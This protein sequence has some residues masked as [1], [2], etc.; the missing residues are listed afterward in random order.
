MR[1]NNTKRRN[2]I[3]AAALGAAL[4]MGGGTFALWSDSASLSGATITAGDLAITT[5]P[6]SG[7][8][9]YDLSGVVDPLDSPSAESITTAIGEASPVVEPFFASPTDVLAVVFEFDITLIGNNLEAELALD[10][11]G[12][13]NGDSTIDTE[14]WDFSYAISAT[15]TDEIPAAFGEV[16][17]GHSAKWTLSDASNN[18][19]VSFVLLVHFKDMTPDGDNIP[20]N[21]D[22]NTVLDL[23]SGVSMTLTQV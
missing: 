9:L 21:Y 14:Y 6:D 22:V 18:A 8:V 23:A 15:D 4:L 7:G 10:M 19:K 20:F 3:I 11:S 16:D 2:G 13:S 1:I 5:P 17:D 12:L